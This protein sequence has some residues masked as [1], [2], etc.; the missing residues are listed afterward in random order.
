MNL[1]LFMFLLVE[2][3]M[4]HVLTRHSWLKGIWRLQTMGKCFPLQA[5]FLPRGISNWHIQGISADPTVFV[6]K[7]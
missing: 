4:V 5:M 7:D 6:R 1:Y 2:R 3:N